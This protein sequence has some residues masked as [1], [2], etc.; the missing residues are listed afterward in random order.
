M[1]AACVLLIITIIRYLCVCVRRMNF[2]LTRP[3]RRIFFVSFLRKRNGK[4]AIEMDGATCWT[5]AWAL[6]RSCMCV[7]CTHTLHSTP[8]TGRYNDD[9]K[10]MAAA[11]VGT[12]YFVAS[13]SGTRHSTNY[14][15]QWERSGMRRSFSNA[16]I[17]WNICVR[18]CTHHKCVYIWWEENKM[19][20]IRDEERTHSEIWNPQLLYTMHPSNSVHQY[21]FFFR[22]YFFL[23][24]F[25]SKVPATIVD[26]NEWMGIHKA[27]G[28]G[29]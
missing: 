7:C 20:T 3:R 9:V 29:G 18:W 2:R 24:R 27:V 19:K 6:R 28:G 4:W 8:M 10:W 23:L 14:E 22:I 12:F 5:S 13:P 1:T 17:L 11:A 25:H 16:H 21:F 26:W 15:L